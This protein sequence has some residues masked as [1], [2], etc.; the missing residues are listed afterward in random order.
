MPWTSAA[1]SRSAWDPSSISAKVDLLACYDLAIITVLLN[2]WRVPMTTPSRRSEIKRRWARARKISTLRRHYKAAKTEGDKRTVQI[3]VY[4][5]D[6]APSAAMNVIVPVEP[7]WTIP[8]YARDQDPSAA[9]IGT[10][11][12]ELRDES[13]AECLD[14]VAICHRPR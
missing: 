11:D 5:V 13:L 14:L 4:R 9:A 7:N 3:T 12:F 10:G 2:D 6:L 8:F 1:P